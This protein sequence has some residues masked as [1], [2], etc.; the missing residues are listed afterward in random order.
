MSGPPSSSAARRARPPA[1]VGGAARLV[2]LARTSYLEATRQPIYGAALLGGLVAVALAPALAVFAIGEADAFVLDLGASALLS[3]SAFLAAVAVGAGAAERFGDG[4]TGLLLT[5]PVGPGTVLLGQLLGGA[6]ALF[7]AGLLLSLVLLWA[8]RH[9]PQELHWGVL[10]CALAAGS[11]AA[12]WGARASL[13][14]RPFQPAALRAATVLFPLAFVISL[15]LGPSAEP[16]GR[17]ASTLPA[18]PSAAY[19]AVLAG[20]PFAGLGLL[21]ATRLGAGASAAGTLL[22]FLA[23][24][25]PSPYPTPLPDLQLFWVGDAAYSGASVPGGYLGAMTLYALAYAL[26]C[27]VLGGASLSAREVA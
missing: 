5:H 16:L 8:V 4:T 2:G 23:A 22:A 24:S 3:F 11:G 12:L 6:L 7:Q 25:L 20:L 1:R 21:L 14:R 18:A 19:L 27:A 10:S 15:R 26:G 17:W 13:A 9:G